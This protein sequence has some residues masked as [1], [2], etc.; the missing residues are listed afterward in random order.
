MKDRP[1]QSAF[2]VRPH[3][4]F[5]NDGNGFDRGAWLDFWRHE[6]TLPH[7][8]PPSPGKLRSQTDPPGV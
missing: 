1:L 6:P 8:A 4:A 2:F 7:L 5:R 3:R